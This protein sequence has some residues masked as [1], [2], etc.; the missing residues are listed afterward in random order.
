VEHYNDAHFLHL[1]NKYLK[2]EG[3]KGRTAKLQKTRWLVQLYKQ[4]RSSNL[5]TIDACDLEFALQSQ[6]S[7]N[8][9]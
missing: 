7:A 1:S 3:D 2:R 6:S 5:E 8:K 4:D 9:W